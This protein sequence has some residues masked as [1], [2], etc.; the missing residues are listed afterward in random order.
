M[1]LLLL[2]G[3]LMLSACSSSPPQASSVNGTEFDNLPAVPEPTQP[4]S[5]PD[6][7]TVAGQTVFLREVFTDIQA[8]WSKDFASA[9]DQY[10]PAKLKL[11][12]KK[13]STACGVEGTETG[14]FYCP[15]DRTVYLDI[16]FF[17]AVEAEFGLSGDFAEAY[18]VAHEMGHHVQNLS[19]ITGRVAS[20]E[21]SSPS[22]SNALSVDVELQA[23][24]LAGVWAHSA[25]QRDLLEPGDIEEALHAAQVVGDDYLAQA[26]GAPVDPD[27]WTHGS[28]AQ[29]QRW[30]TTGY[31]ERAP[32]RLQ[33]LHRFLT[34]RA[35]QAD[36]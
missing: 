13:V 16:S 21:S 8:M 17:R 15:G 18:V 24:C 35:G 30:F 25:Y 32:R 1:A 31:R 36:R 11:F 3:A 22:S 12:T 33:H 2:A 27:S 6:L 26:A 7:S 9:G 14:P 23:D 20:L 29:R 28:S 19:G 5:A 4:P 34:P 10:V